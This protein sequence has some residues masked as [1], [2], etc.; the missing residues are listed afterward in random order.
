MN[1]T[2]ALLII[3]ITL[4]GCSIKTV[5]ISSNHKQETFEI[6]TKTNKE[7][8]FET[9]IDFLTNNQISTRTIDKINGLVITEEMKLSWS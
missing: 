3:I 9:I 6:Q 7:K 1:W 8:C 4:N 2:L 5:P